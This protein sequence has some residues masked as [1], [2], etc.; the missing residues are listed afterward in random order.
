MVPTALRKSMIDADHD[1]LCADVVGG[2]FQIR[3]DGADF[4]CTIKFNDRTRRYQIRSGDL[5]SHFHARS[6]GGRRSASTFTQMLNRSQ[7]FRLIPKALGVVYAN[8]TF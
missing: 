8:G 4:I 2:E 7:A 6:T 1:D 5:D 3:I